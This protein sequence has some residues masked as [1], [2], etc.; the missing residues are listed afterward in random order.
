MNTD[1]AATREVEKLKRVVL[2][3]GKHQEAMLLP[4]KCAR[5]LLDRFEQ[6]PVRR[7]LAAA[8][9]SRVLHGWHMGRESYTVDCTPDG[10]VINKW[11]A[12]SKP[13]VIRH[14]DAGS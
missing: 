10:A 13:A 4:P 1:H 3:F 7:Q 8:V 14:S 9:Y 5:M 2:D 12:A 6:I 11:I